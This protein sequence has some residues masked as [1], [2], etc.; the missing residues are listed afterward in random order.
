MNVIFP[1]DTLKRLFITGQL[2]LPSVYVSIH[3]QDLTLSLTQIQGLAY[4]C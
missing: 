3:Q 2:G 1:P 4:F